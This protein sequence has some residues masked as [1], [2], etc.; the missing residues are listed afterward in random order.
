M[1]L[2]YYEW[3]VVW[4]S[5][6]ICRDEKETN[7]KMKRFSN[8][9]KNEKKKEEKGS[10]H[11]TL[12]I[13][14]CRHTFYLLL[15]CFVFNWIISASSFVVSFFAPEYCKEIG[16]SEKK[17][18]TKIIDLSAYVTYIQSRVNSFRLRK[19]RRLAFLLFLSYSLNVNLHWIF[20]PI[21]CLNCVFS[22][23]V[24]APGPRTSSRCSY[25]N[26]KLIKECHWGQ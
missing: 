8:W 9:L 6:S 24:S 21:R 18:E 17:N 15:F 16:Q 11:I 10:D 13:V 22:F 2:T 1:C 26:D 4:R 5:V 3:T 20:R 14:H 12:C 23:S 19:K 7:N 25:R